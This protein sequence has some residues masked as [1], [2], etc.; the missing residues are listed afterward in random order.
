MIPIM[1]HRD[2]RISLNF[3]YLIQ[4]VT[5]PTHKDG[6]TLDLIITRSSEDI[7]SEVQVHPPQIISNYSSI[8]FKIHVTKL[9]PIKKEITLGN[10]S[11][12]I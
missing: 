8:H 2:S 5:S 1:M 12:W 3:I 11:D 4:H 9:G 7:V 6:H 10:F